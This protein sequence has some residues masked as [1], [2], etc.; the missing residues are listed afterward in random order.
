MCGALDPFCFWILYFTFVLN[1]QKSGQIE[2][3]TVAE[4]GEVESS[5]DS[6]EEEESEVVMERIFEIE[7]EIEKF[8]SFE[9]NIVK[10]LQNFIFFHGLPKFT[11][12]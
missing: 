7:R 2:I 11:P 9:L 10:K 6:E 1:P 12:G 3:E 8:W 5:T 4:S